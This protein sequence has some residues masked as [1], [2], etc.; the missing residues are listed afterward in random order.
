MEEKIISQHLKR[1]RWLSLNI[2]LEIDYFYKTYKIFPECGCTRIVHICVSG[3]LALKLR[4]H[5]SEIMQAL[6]NPSW[7]NLFSQIAVVIS[8]VMFP[9]VF[10]L[11]NKQSFTEVQLFAYY[12]SMT[13]YFDILLSDITESVIRLHSSPSLQ[14]CNRQK[15]FQLTTHVFEKVHN[16]TAKKIVLDRQGHYIWFLTW[17]MWINC[18]DELNGFVVQLFVKLITFDSLLIQFCTS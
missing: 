12:L 6:L 11:T 8:E 1:K 15:Y 13:M 9:W 14:F 2:G 16:W 5:D 17:I 4:K 3:E 7:W 10:F 18:L